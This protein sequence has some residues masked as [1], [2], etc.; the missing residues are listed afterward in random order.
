M[1]TINLYENNLIDGYYGFKKNI[2]NVKPILER[3][4]KKDKYFI[5]SNKIFKKDPI[6]GKTKFLYIKT[7]NNKYITNPRH[8]FINSKQR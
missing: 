1:S 4:I 6:K 2:I 8:K 7:K 5:V 3:Y